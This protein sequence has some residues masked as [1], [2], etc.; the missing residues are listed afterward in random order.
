M[1]K[2]FASVRACLILALMTLSLGCLG[3]S[4]RTNDAESA[5]VDREESLRARCGNGRCGTNESC[6]TCPRDCG[7]CPSCDDELGGTVR[8]VAA[9]GGGD[10]TTLQAAANVTLPGD[11]VLIRN[12]NYAPFTI[13]RSG[14]AGLPISYRAYPG[15]RPVI[16]GAAGKHNI[17]IQ[18]AA[19]PAAP[20][21]WLVLDGLEVAS[22]TIEGIKAYNLHDTTIRRCIVHHSYQNGVLIVGSHNIL[23]ERNTVHSGSHYDA[24]GRYVGHAIYATGN[25]WQVLNNVFH[26]NG[27]YGIQVAGYSHVEISSLLVE[28]EHAD[29]WTIAHNTFALQ[30]DRSGVVLWP[31]NDW[32][33]GRVSNVRIVNNVFYRNSQSANGLNGGTPNGVH[34]YPSSGVTLNNNVYAG[35]APFVVAYSGV[36]YQASGNIAGDPGFVNPTGADFHLGSTSAAADAGTSTNAPA[37]DLEGGARPAGPGYDAGAYERGAVLECAF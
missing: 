10:F 12:G 19:G 23:F 16:V 20:I 18:A 36:T 11:T 8:V 35:A 5:D 14:T 24:S 31:G 21:G 9:N 34:L 27:A 30:K 22:S 29:D 4:P 13:T 25:H 2:T 37:E 32:S 7:S 26:D 1:K 33:T 3:E 17:L 28:N 6:T 15:E